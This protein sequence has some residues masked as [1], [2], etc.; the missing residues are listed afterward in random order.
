[1]PSAPQQL[2]ISKSFFKEIIRKVLKDLGT[3]LYLTLRCST[4]NDSLNK[5]CPP[6]QW[7]AKQALNLCQ[8]IFSDCERCLLSAGKDI[9]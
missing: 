8:R 1:M 4:I 3:K 7:N 2:Y 5:S 9:H 6:A